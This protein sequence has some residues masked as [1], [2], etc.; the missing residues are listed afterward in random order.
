MSNKSKIDD[1]MA[2]EHTKARGRAKKMRTS[3]TNNSVYEENLKAMEIKVSDYWNEPLT[4]EQFEKLKPHVVDPLPSF[5]DLKTVATEMQKEHKVPID[6]IDFLYEDVPEG[7]FAEIF[8]FMERKMKLQKLM[9]NKNTKAFLKTGWTSNQTGF[10]PYDNARDI[11]QLR[12]MTYQLFKIL[13][14]Q[15]MWFQK[16]HAAKES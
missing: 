13:I 3:K 15:M 14:K 12:H 1:V 4:K 9:E 11:H 10:K 8:A 6:G 2:S 16:F 7:D 5:E